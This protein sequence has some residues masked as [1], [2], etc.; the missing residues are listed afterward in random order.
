MGGL[1][2]STLALASRAAYGAQ[3]IYL[4]GNPQTSFFGNPPP[5]QSTKVQQHLKKRGRPR[6]ARLPE[7]SSTLASID[8]KIEL[9]WS[10]KNKVM[11][12]T[13]MK[14]KEELTLAMMRDM[15]VR[16]HQLR[17]PLFSTRGTHERYTHFSSE[18]LKIPLN[19]IKL[20]RTINNVLPCGKTTGDMI[21]KMYIELQI[22]GNN[23]DFVDNLGEHIIKNFQIYIG[24]QLISEYDNDYMKIYNHMKDGNNSLYKNL[25]QLDEGCLIIPLLFWFCK[26]STKSL[27]IIALQ[28]HEVEIRL[29]FESL[30]KI[31]KGTDVIQITGSL[32]ADYIYILDTKERKR[33]VENSHEFLI[34][35]VQM[36]EYGVSDGSYSLPFSHPCKELFWVTKND[37]TY[38][39]SIKSASIMGLE[40]KDAIYYNKIQPYQYNRHSMKGVYM[41][42]FSLHP[43]DS[44]QPSGTCNFSRIDNATLS[45][46][47]H[48]TDGLKIK[49]YAVN[50]NVLRIISGMGGLAYSK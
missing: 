43:S 2:S 45:C 20:G 38:I 33:L 44:V 10:S 40:V 28:Y 5:Q 4:T 29:E 6:D 39:N 48:K 49:I 46:T 14:K 30:E 19:N 13:A 27:P 11:L 26:D 23:D 18:N 35:Q 22:S 9:A 15:P 32:M 12:D 1:N 50:Y 34:E 37:T 7:H 8:K 16:P 42:S 21:H 25:I 41:H 3:D 31:Y 36:I 47:H 24:G 17:A